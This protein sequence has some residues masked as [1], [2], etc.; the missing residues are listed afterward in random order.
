MPTESV[1][2]TVVVVAVFTFFSVLL[3]WV[4]SQAK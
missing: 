3:A 2:V 1:V 4:S